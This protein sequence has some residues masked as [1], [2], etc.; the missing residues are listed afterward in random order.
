MSSDG[1]DLAAP[2]VYHPP[3]VEL[4]A[5]AGFVRLRYGLTG[6]LEPLPSER[7]LNFKVAMPTGDYVVKVA[8]IAESRAL[9]EVQA[10]AL[11]RVA[12]A[13]VPGPRL[14]KASTGERLVALEAPGGPYLVRVLT[15]VDGVPLAT[16]NPKGPATLRSLGQ[17]LGRIDVA[18]AGWDPPAA[19]RHLKWDLARAD[20][21]EGHWERIEDPER[22]AMA[23]RLFGPYRSQVLP[24][25]GDLRQSV[26]YN[27]A[28]DYNV[29]VAAGP[30]EPRAVSGV[31][32]FGDLVRSATVGDLAIGCAYAMLDSADPLAAAGAVVA[33]YQEVD[34]LSEF[35]LEALYPLILA[36]LVTSAVNSALQRS[37]APENEYLLISE[38]PVWR[39]LE[40]LDE[41]HPRFGWYRLRQAAGVEP[42]PRSARVRRWIEA[43]HDAA[44]PIIPTPDPI[45]PPRVDLSVGSPFLDDLRLAHDEPRLTE[46]IDGLRRQVDAR[47]AVGEYDEARLV[48]TSAP[49]QTAGWDGP[50]W[51]T[52]HLG[53]DLFAEVGTPVRTPIAG[54]VHSVRNNAGPLDYGPTVI[55]EHRV[56]DDAGPFV[57]YTLHGH[58]DL[59]TLRDMHP[60]LPL[61]AGATVG[62][63]G[64]PAVNG[65][66]SPHVHFQVI[67]DLLDRPGEFPGVARPSERL[68]WLSLSPPPNDLAGVARTRR[69]DELTDESILAR[70]RLLMGGNLSVSYRRPLHIVRGWMQH[71]YDASGRRFLDAVNN[72]PHVGHCHPRVVEA[73][74]RQMAVLNTN[75]RYL[76]ETVVRYAERLTATLPKPLSVCYF[77]NSGSEANELALRLA[78]ARTGRRGTIVVDGAYHGN[79]ATLVSLS[80]YKCEGPGGTGLAPFARKVPLPDRYRG[81]HRTGED[82]LGERYAE[83]LSEA[84]G[85]LEREGHGAAAFLCESILSC[86][87]QIVLP[88]GYLAAA[89]RRI[90]AAGGLAIADEVQVGFGRVG[91]RFWGF[92]TQDVVP[93]IVVMGKPAGNGHPL[94]VVAT[95]PEIAASFANGMEFFSTFGGNPVSAAIG[96]AVLETIDDEDL[97]SRADIVGSHLLARLGELKAKHPPVGDVRGMG[98]FVG[99]ELVGS[100]ERRDPNPAAA[101]YLANRMRDAGILVS[102]DG[103]DHNVIKIKPP[104][105]FGVDDADR[106]VEAMDRILGE[107]ACRRP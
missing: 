81:R 9:L 85:S 38:Q 13:G 100:P 42:C 17:L 105:C 27:D 67:V 57:F 53:L 11:E 49:F 72:V 77:V 69:R 78:W 74:R 76:H 99:V 93:D 37:A 50:E 1:S 21:I 52:V 22:R 62:R 70:R 95:T 86:G 31:I 51:R 83:Y 45:L 87:G 101:S 4:G 10:E 7:D 28:N 73:G 103:P 64:S 19:R 54:R 96:L 24:R 89:Y 65:G 36:R 46:R 32:D 23:M 102:T 66:W 39:L 15:W 26:I 2:V 55:V 91:R 25:W 63:L 60:G 106:L 56:K 80:P 18:L 92:E 16:I 44:M 88:D 47:Y 59:E 98:L 3:T 94:G 104:L 5:L 79:T 75:T 107:D 82:Q 34:P 30:E 68:T 8:N 29:L 35:E 41:I 14:V 97:Q 33:G 43:N 58:L 71:L 6:E 90:R 48:Y 40:R 61:N 84:I 12:N 20:W